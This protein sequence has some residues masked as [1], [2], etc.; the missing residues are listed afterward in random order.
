MPK[1]QKEFIPNEGPFLVYQSAKHYPTNRSLVNAYAFLVTRGWGLSVKKEI[2][3]SSVN[4][5]AN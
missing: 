5:V 3:N 4:P 2:R 1:I